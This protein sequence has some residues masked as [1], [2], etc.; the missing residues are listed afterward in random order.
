MRTPIAGEHRLATLEGRMTTAVERGQ[1]QA[2]RDA[3]LVQ[4][5]KCRRILDKLEHGV[6]QG[7]G[8]YGRWVPS[9]AFDEALYWAELQLHRARHVQERTT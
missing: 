3:A 9:P 5:A 2:K 7:H 6:K 8:K 4:L 1:D